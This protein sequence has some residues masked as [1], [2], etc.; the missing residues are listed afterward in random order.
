MRIGVKFVG[1]ITSDSLSN[2]FIPHNIQN[3]SIKNFLIKKEHIFLLSWTE[4]KNHSQLAFNS[5]IEE[6][7][8]QGIC[9]YCWE[10][11][12][13]ITDVQTKLRELLSRGILLSFAREGILI[14]TKE[15]L[16]AFFENYFLA[17]CIQQSGDLKQWLN[18]RKEY[19]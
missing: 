6:N 15:E 13:N 16:E 1:Y 19:F 4:Y 8:F 18:E 17:N 7:Y 2:G 5:L 3:L 9:F 12:Q 10:Q 11:L 14:E